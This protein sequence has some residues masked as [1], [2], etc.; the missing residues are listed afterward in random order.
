[1]WVIQHCRVTLEDVKKGQIV[2]GEV[3][4]RNGMEKGFGLREGE[5]PSFWQEQYR[6]RRVTPQRK[7]WEAPSS[8]AVC[9][10]DSKQVC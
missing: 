5:K 4:D 2:D 1:M 3:H 9:I 6:Y 10:S 7:V 8:G